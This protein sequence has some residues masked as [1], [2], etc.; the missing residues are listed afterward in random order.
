MLLKV[1]LGETS[2]PHSSPS[3]TA[4]LETDLGQTEKNKW[5]SIWDCL[6]NRN[7]FRGKEEKPGGQELTHTLPLPPVRLE[8]EEETVV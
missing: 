1:V 7:L 2:V 8:R 4:G 3:H 5:S 6:G